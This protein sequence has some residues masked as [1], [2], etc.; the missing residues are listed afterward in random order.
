MGRTF[1]WLDWYIF[2]H[3]KRRGIEVVYWVL[4]TQ[5]DFSRAIRAGVDGIITDCPQTLRRYLDERV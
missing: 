2:P 5:K 3:L 1:N 4:N